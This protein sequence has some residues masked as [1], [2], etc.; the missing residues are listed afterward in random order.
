MTPLEGILKN[1]LLIAAVFGLQKLKSG[2]TFR[3]RKASIALAL[4][5][6]LALPFILNPIYS[7]AA[8]FDREA[9]DY[10]L[11]LDIL[12]NS[13]TNTPPHKDL[14]NGKWLIAYISLTCPHCKIAAYKLHILQKNNPDLPIYMVLNGK[15]E[16]IEPFFEK[17]KANNISYSMFSG[18]S[19]FLKMSGPAL[20]AIFMVENGVVYKKTDYL[21]LSEKELLEWLE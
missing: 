6:T 20:P 8:N 15:D 16:N 14:K 5:I 11:P 13:S 21:D 1:I 7:G 2:F 3:F 19:E 9:K 17:T 10:E 4:L 12:Y 18:G